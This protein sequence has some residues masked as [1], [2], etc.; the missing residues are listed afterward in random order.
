MFESPWLK[1]SGAIS[2]PATNEEQ[3]GQRPT[4]MND[5]TTSIR[6]SRSPDPPTTVQDSITNY[7]S[8]RDQDPG[9]D[10]LRTPPPRRSSRRGTSAASPVRSTSPPPTYNYRGFSTSIGDMF[11]HPSSERVDCCSMT[12]CGMFQ[13]DR[14]RY[15]LQ[16]VSPPSPWKRCW[17]HIGLPVT[18]FLMAGYV[19]LHVPDVVLNEILCLVFLLMLLVGILVQCQKGRVKRMNIRKDVLWYKYLL[20][21]GRR[22]GRGG[23]HD[24][25]TRTLD[26][27][28]DQPR[29]DDDNEEDGYYFN[30][31][32]HRDIGC[33]HPYCFLLGCYPTDKPGP[34]ARVNAALLQGPAGDHNQVED[35]LCSCLFKTFC[36]PCC[37]MYLQL[38]GICGMAQE[39]REIEFT[40]LPP[41]YRRLDYVTMQPMMQY[42]EE[43]YNH[44][45]KRFHIHDA[46]TTT[47]EGPTVQGPF[48]EWW[49]NPGSRLSQL[50]KILLQGWLALTLFLGIWGFVGPLFWTQFLRGE[51]RR[52]YFGPYDFVVYLASWMVSMFTFGIVL[53]LAQTKGGTNNNNNTNKPLELSMDAMIKYF[54]CG[55]VLSTTLSIFY[56]LVVGLTI[57]LAMMILLA[58]S[59][60]DQ[61]RDNEYSYAEWVVEA[62]L[63][64]GFG[65]TGPPLFTKATTSMSESTAAAAAADVGAEDYL[66]VFGRDHPV[67]YSIYLFVNAFFL[68]ALVEE[69]C[70]YFGYRMMEHPDF[71]S[72]QDLEDAARAG[73]ARDHVDEDDDDDD[74]DSDDGRRQASARSNA[75][76]RHGAAAETGPQRQQRRLNFA[77]HGKSLQ[78]QGTS[79]TVAMVCVAL[80][81]S[82]CEDLVY[83]FLYSGS[84]VGMEIYVLLARTLFPIHVICAAMQSIGVTGRDV[85]KMPTRFGRV[86]LPAILFH[87]TYDFLV[88]WI[89][90]LTGLGRQDGYNEADEELAM[91]RNVIV[92][93]SISAVLMTI[94]LYWYYRESKRQRE[95]LAQ[96][97]ADNLPEAAGEMA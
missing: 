70:K 25:T 45:W 36:S 3:G 31:Q 64:L 50:S 55:F 30:G 96:L 78:A 76:R 95:R 60:I 19:A 66:P 42:Y 63:T 46:M 24:D 8:M 89:D 80:G 81:F 16:G 1:F 91:A 29:P 62:P 94:A 73:S 9:E 10:P 28:L 21:Q 54:G 74:D 33:S 43:I 97:D 17:V 44:R 2:S 56:E 35:S 11:A 4:T 32:T 77:R 93:Y 5:T 26:Q 82:L 69:I 71:M 47:G 65:G 57:R 59:G 92:S 83:I 49:N 48:A 90:F 72:Q 20:H 88:L 41:A 38:G 23:G 61:V 7:H 58:F 75:T 85:E 18:L 22:Q 37:G 53:C 15:L 6:R 27:I 51:G 34:A 39:S 14:D 67:I 79:I 86:L 84:S 12:C 52:H 87:G 13:S 40:L 68:A